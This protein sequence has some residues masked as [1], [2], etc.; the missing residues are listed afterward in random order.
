MTTTELL[1]L[2]SALSG[3]RDGEADVERLMYTLY[4]RREIDIG[5]AAMAAG[6]VIS[7]E[8]VERRIRQWTK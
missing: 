3:G 6:E 2:M 8:E 5:E 1:E 7:Q 4:L